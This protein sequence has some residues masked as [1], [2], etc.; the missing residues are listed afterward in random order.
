MT[1]S[2]TSIE[3]VVAARETSRKSCDFKA[4][5]AIRD[6]LKAQYAQPE[7][8]MTL[9]HTTARREL[10]EVKICQSLRSEVAIDTAAPA[11]QR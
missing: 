1:P 10:R 11:K 9:G 6:D 5:D 3:A 7:C 4:V 8:V 2:L